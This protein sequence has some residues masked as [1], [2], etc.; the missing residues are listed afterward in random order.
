[1]GLLSAADF[2]ANGNYLYAR[3]FGKLAPGDIRYADLVEDGIINGADRE[4]LGSTIPRF[5]YSLN[6]NAAYKG[7][8]FSVFFQGVGKRDGYLTGNAIQPFLSGG[9]AYE[10]QKNRWTIENPDPNA[11]FPRLA[12]GETNN[13]Q[14]SDYWMK[15]AAYLRIKNIQLGYTIPKQVLQRAGISQ[16]RI[17]L[18]GENLFTMD[19]FWPG[20]DPEIDAASNGAYYPQVKTYNLGINL[21]F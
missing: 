3:Q 20:W 13:T 7:F 14:L 10:Y 18:S 8:D 15:S 16:L 4:V 5:T 2:D 17:Y 21:K 1:M 11:V 12:F 9:T 6:L 19:H